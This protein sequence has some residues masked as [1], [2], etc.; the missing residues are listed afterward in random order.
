MWLPLQIDI[1]VNNWLA[2]PP[3]GTLRCPSSGVFGAVAPG[4][5][6]PAVGYDSGSARAAMIRRRCSR[7][8]WA[9]AGRW[10]DPASLDLSLRFGGEAAGR[11]LI[12]IEPPERTSG[13]LAVVGIIVWFGG[14]IVAVDVCSSM[15][16]PRHPGS[17]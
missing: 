8:C 12:G 14:E 5:L 16:N 13:G 3:C 10:I 7:G 15:L 9:C 17:R 4:Q 1:S 11:D 6:V 2:S